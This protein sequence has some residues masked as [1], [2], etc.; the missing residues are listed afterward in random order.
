MQGDLSRD[1]SYQQNQMQLAHEKAQANAA[2]GGFKLMQNQ[3]EDYLQNLLARRG[4]RGRLDTTSLGSPRG[5]H[6]GFGTLPLAG[7]A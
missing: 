5:R 4:H 6:A 2:M 7:G 1:A 3:Y